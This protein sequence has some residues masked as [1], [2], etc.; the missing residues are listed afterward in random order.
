MKDINIL[1]IEDNEGD[2]LL[3][4]EAFE[5]CR[6]V[7]RINTIKDG[8]LAIG[9]FESLGE[10]DDTPHLVLLDI[11][12][13]RANGHEVLNYIKSHEKYRTIPVI[14]LTTSSA[15]SDILKSYNNH[16]NCYIT[17]PIDLEDFMIVISKIESF[18]TSTVSLPSQ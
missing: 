7:N 5:E 14:M 2:I 9:Y 17:K 11:N 1:L 6:L 12:L 16:V 4:V 15:Q 18:W 13:P 3:T 8:K 10:R